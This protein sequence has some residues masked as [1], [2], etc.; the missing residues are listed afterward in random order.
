MIGST[1]IPVSNEDLDEVAALSG[2]MAYGDDYLEPDVRENCERIIPE[3]ET[4]RPNDAVDS[5]LF[6]KAHYRHQ[7]Q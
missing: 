2:V 5:F 4:V 1:G 6:L 3:V 7:G